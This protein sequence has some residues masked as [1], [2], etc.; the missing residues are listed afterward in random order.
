MLNGSYLHVKLIIT[1]LAQGSILQVGLS[2]IIQRDSAQV[3]A[4]IVEVGCETERVA[5]IN[6][7][8]M[9]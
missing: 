3:Q 2:Q 7:G 4:S 1:E 9:V 6:F 5:Q 8:E